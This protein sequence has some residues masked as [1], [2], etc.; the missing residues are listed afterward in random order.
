M[1]KLITVLVALSLIATSCESL[2][3]DSSNSKDEVNDGT[4]DDDE[5]IIPGDSDIMSGYTM[6]SQTQQREP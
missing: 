6:A 5:D 2:F 1:K 3:E 4:N